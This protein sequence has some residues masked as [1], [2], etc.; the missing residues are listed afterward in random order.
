MAKQSADPSPGSGDPQQDDQLWTLWKQ[1]GQEL[2]ALR[3]RQGLAVRQLADKAGVSP[4]TVIDLEHGWRRRPDGQRVL[5]NPRDDVLGRL[6]G[7]LA[8]PPERLFAKVGRHAERPQ[9]RKGWR[10]YARGQGDAGAGDLEQRLARTERL[11]GRIASKLGTTP[12]ELEAELDAE[13]SDE[14]PRR[15]RGRAG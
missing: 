14:S 2:F 12:E 7:A 9:T 5:P 11:L 15:R 10:G 4:Q 8:V 6:A 1:F 3:N 13:D